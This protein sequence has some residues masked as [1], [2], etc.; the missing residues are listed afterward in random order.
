MYEILV[1]FVQ[2]HSE[3]VSV[4]SYRQWYISIAPFASRRS[5]RV[6]TIE[7]LYVVEAIVAQK[8][9][10]IKFLGIIHMSERHGNVI[11]YREGK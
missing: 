8:W 1:K 6:H 3:S 7:N 10:I 5:S 11:V 4:A 2:M 9:E